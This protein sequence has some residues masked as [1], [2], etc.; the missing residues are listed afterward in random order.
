MRMRS[1]RVH[2]RRGTVLAGVLGASATLL[3]AVST[4]A[5]AARRK[6]RPSGGGYTPPYAAMVVDAKTGRTLYAEN[7]DE[8]RFPASVTKVMT[9]YLLFEQLERGKVSLST[10]LRISE[11]GRAHV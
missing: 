5:E 10:P 7:E 9:L 11:I 2:R 1:V 6:A 8:P 4:P 3:L